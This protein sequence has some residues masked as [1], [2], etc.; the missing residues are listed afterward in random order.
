MKIGSYE[1]QV[2][3]VT[4]SSD[5]LKTVIELA[6]IEPNQRIIDLGS[7][8]GRVVIEFAKI[9]AIVDGYEIKEGLVH[10]SKERIANAGL[11][12]KTTVYQ[13][14][15]WDVDLS[16]YEIVYIYGMQSILGRLEKKLEAEM[17]P[18]AKFISNIFRLPHWKPKKIKNNVNLYIK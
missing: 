18:G 10:R 5:N 6:N 4:T 13:K 9:G 16:T 1:I 8:D 14:N 15:F 17:K 11:E 2:P 7:G 12:G 3:F